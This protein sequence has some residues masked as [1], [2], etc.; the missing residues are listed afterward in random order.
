MAS[1]YVGIDLHRRRPVTVRQAPDGQV[2]DTV[3]TDNDPVA[4]SCAIAGAGPDPEVV[5]EATYG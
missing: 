5:V 4:L 2:V 3:R 1:Q